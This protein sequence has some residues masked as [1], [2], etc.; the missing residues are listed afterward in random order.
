MTLKDQLSADL[1]SAL[2]AGDETRK[3]TL[4]ALLAALQQALLDKRAATAREKGKG[5]ELSD[6][7][8][9][10]LDHLALDEAEALAAVQKEAKARRESIADA[11]QAHRADLVAANQAELAIIAGYLPQALTREEIAALVEAAIAET[12]AAD[13][14]QLGAVMKALT[15]RTKG[16]ADGR[17][18]NEVV[19]ERLSAPR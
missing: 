3:T 13:L 7:Q 6:A 15:P 12:G 9:A 1:K 8:V 19:R 16:R 11:E 10:E 17:L 18:V 5:V 4:R 2:K 14:K